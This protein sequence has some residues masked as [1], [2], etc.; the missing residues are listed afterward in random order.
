MQRLLLLLL[1]NGQRVN[2]TQNLCL[3]VCVC[4]YSAQRVPQSGGSSLVTDQPI[5]RQAD[6]AVIKTHNER[7]VAKLDKLISNCNCYVLPATC[8]LLRATCNLLHASDPVNS[9]S[10]WPCVFDT[11]LP[12]RNCS[13]S[14]LVE[15]AYEK[16]SFIYSEPVRSRV[17]RAIFPRSRNTS[18]STTAM[19]GGN[20]NG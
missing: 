5:G 2:Q 9:L 7:R 17:K 3:C 18:H 11:W 4:V 13:D 19:L 15:V 12:K 20:R 16:Y 6:A 1:A 10:G 14:K 8:Y